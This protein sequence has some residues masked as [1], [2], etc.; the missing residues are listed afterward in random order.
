[1][2]RARLVLPLLAAGVAAWLWRAPPVEPPLDADAPR[3]TRRAGDASGEVVE[4]L[5]APHSLDRPFRSMQGPST[6]QRGITLLPGAPPELLW[7]TGA[8]SEV[9]LEDG[10]GSAAPRYLCHANLMLDR[11]ATPGLASRLITLAPGR[12]GISLPAGYGLPVLSNQSLDVYSMALNRDAGAVPR[13]IRFRTRIE[14]TRDRD[15]A[16]IMQPLALRALYVTEPIGDRASVHAHADHGGGGEDSSEHGSVN[17]SEGGV[18]D[19]FGVSRTIHWI[20]P[21]GTREYRADVTDQLELSA[22]TTLLYATGHLHPFGRSISLRDLTEDRT[23]LTVR[24]IEPADPA[25]EPSI[26][27]IVIREGVPLARDHRYELVALYE[28]RTAEPVDAMAILYLYVGDRDF[29]RPA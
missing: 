23:V 27:E 14:F 20:V 21:P 17:A 7:I 16:A 10:E 11:G 9:I 18:M 13:R 5:S 24:Q 28:N 4:L 2:T 6:L 26:D 12:S 22:D 19:R 25:A 29:R 3:V 15:T 8:R 1:M